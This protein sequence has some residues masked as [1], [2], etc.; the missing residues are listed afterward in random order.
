ME[1][2][3]LDDFALFI[4]IAELGSLRQASIAL[5]VPM[6]TLSRRL[7]K[8]EEKLGCKLLLRGNG[9]FALTDAGRTYFDQLRPL[10]TEMN[11]TLESIDTRH[12]EPAGILKIALPVNLARSWLA[13]FFST[14][15]RNHPHIDLR[16]TLS[17]RVLPLGE[18]NFDVAIRVGKQTQQSLVLRKLCDTYLVACAAPEY[19]AKFGTPTSP[20]ELRYHAMIVASPLRT[21]RLT[22]RKT[23]RNE[24]FS[25]DGRFDVDE[26]ELASL[27]IEEGHGIG[28]VPHSII[29]NSLRAGRLVAL[30]PDW[31]TEQR[32]I[33]AVWPET[34]FMPKR[35][36]V[37]ID[38][39]VAFA[40][41]NPA[42]R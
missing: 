18:F 9:R 14:F 12:N 10:V 15:L 23:G 36:R 26:I 24:V 37:F 6:A 30:L 19:L 21:W 13:P 7:Q 3:Q 35:Q 34:D 4:R 38:E 28:L 16:L 2:A 40:T 8:L 17:N 42:D 20:E 31:E 22:H 29:S 41:Q 11:R 1:H 27:M 5:E 25:V 33:F 32:D 39:L